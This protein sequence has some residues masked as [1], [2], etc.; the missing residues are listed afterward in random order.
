MV[1]MKT[2][3]LIL[4]I[5]LSSFL[6][7]GVS[8]HLDLYNGLKNDLVLRFETPVDNNESILFGMHKITQFSNNGNRALIL[9]N[10]ELVYRRYVNNWRHGLFASFGFRYGN[11]LIENDEAIETDVLFMPFFDCGYK[12]P[13]SEKITQLIALDV[14]YVITYA[15]DISVNDLNLIAQ[16]IS[17]RF[18]LLKIKQKVVE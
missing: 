16:E 11:T 14:G 5:S 7:N 4:F 2:V 9:T 3:I 10:W 17:K 6:A 12:I 8:M 15:E 1:T 13:L 18:G